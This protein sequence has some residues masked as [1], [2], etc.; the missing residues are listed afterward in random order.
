MTESSPEDGNKR[1]SPGD[2]APAEGKPL[3]TWNRSRTKR[4]KGA[5]VDEEDAFQRGMRE[6][7]KAAKS[8]WRLLV[9]S[10]VAAVML[11]GAGLFALNKSNESA[12]ER[13]R[14]LSKVGAIVGRGVVV[15]EDQL[16]PDLSRATPDPL[17]TSQ[18]AKQEAYENYLSELESDQNASS[19]ALMLRAA[20][21]LRRGDSEGAVTNY[22]AFIAEAGDDH[23]LF[24]L[25]AEGKGIA[26]ENSGKLDE[27]LKVYEGLAGRRG[28]FFRDMALWHQGRTLEALGRTEDARGVYRTYVEEFPAEVSS[29]AREQVRERLEQLDPAALDADTP[30]TGA[31]PADDAGAGVG[32]NAPKAGG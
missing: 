31:A 26:L 11:L 23:P 15:D 24:F 14:A 3:P 5:T 22:D 28:S 29:L 16:P 20:E 19:L 6:G 25:A 9:L 12:A 10:G 13:T 8:R 32:P 2:G 21:Q 18:E 27:A 17:F 7:S 30:P 1:T 4:K